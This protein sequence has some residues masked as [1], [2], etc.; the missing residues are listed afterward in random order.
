MVDISGLVKTAFILPNLN[1]SE[2]SEILSSERSEMFQFGEVSFYFQV[3]TK[4]FYRR[5]IK[6]I[7]VMTDTTGN[8]PYKVV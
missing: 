7:F 4:L 8:Y 3:Q 6:K 1:Y 2:F 5:S